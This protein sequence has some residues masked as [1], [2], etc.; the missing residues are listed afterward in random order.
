MNARAAL[1]NTIAVAGLCGF[2]VACGS[3]DPDALLASA[4]NYL[5][6]NDAKSAVIQLKNALEKNPDIAEAR[7]LLGRTLL[8]SGD[9]LAAEK[10]LR[11]ARDLKYPAAQVDPPLALAWVRMGE[12]QKVVDEFSQ[13]Q[14]ATPTGTAELRA[15]VGQAQLALH[16]P[17]LARTAFADAQ[18]ADPGYTPAMIGE[19]RLKARD[20][21]LA[22]ALALA[23]RALAASPDSVEAWQFKGDVLRAQNQ[24]ANA[25]AAYR[26]VIALKP[27]HLPAH[28]A[29]VTVL[30][31]E[32]DSASAWS[33]PA[34]L[35]K[36][37]PKH[38]QTY[39]LEAL[40][41]AA[42]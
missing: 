42:G 6:K 12:N 38:P 20:G 24:V 22:G 29:L 37:A 19:A 8:E 5:A 10:E 21:D 13:A 3:G 15:A 34:A 17:D 27:D 9:T 16:K 1:V 41:R 35:K 25:I 23:E 32:G 14:G 28:W 7:F 36:I 26:K 39:Y 4:K 18:R 31:R 2:L 33:A 11:R 30:V 40:A